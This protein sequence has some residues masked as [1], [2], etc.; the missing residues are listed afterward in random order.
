MKKKYDTDNFLARWASGTLSKEEEDAFK[1]TE[2]YAYF[3]AILNG[4]DAL[5]VPVYDNEALFKKV[6]DR[7]KHTKTKVVKL[8]PKWGYA[9]AASIALLLAYTFFFNGTVKEATG[10]GEQLAITLP[11]NSEVILNAKSKI[12]YNNE[13]WENNRTLLLNGEAF[14]KVNKGSTF[15]VNTKQGSVTVLGTQ[16]TANSHDDIFEVIC[17]E[18]RV[19]VEHGQEFDIITKGEAIRLIDNTFEKWTLNNL[20]PSWA[21]QTESSF[22][23]AP[24]KQV[25]TALEHQYNIKVKTKN[26]D[27]NAYRFTGSF[28]HSNLKSALKAVFDPLE[29][30]FNFTNKKTISLSN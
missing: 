27:V 3:E 9:V 24:L 15:T 5:K 12:K 26:I 2:D 8:F 22:T 10:Y 11:D 21:Q 16:F 20:Q 7:K 1:K 28:N 18:G 17:Y 4:T 23:N 19:K 29:V 25:I 30:T 13:D 14:F 6:Q